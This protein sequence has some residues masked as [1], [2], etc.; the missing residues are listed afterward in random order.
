MQRTAAEHGV[1]EEQIVAGITRNIALGKIP[2]D[3]DCA[4]AALFLVSDYAAAVT[5]ATLDANG[6][7]YMAP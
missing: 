6:G 3:D 1:P 7:D 2:T 4:R 5:G